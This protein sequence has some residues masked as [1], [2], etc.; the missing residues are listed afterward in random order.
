MACYLLIQFRTFY[1]RFLVSQVSQYKINTFST[2]KSMK[3]NKIVTFHLDK[4]QGGVGVS[5]INT[6]ER[7]CPRMLAVVRF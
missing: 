5:S 7:F 1:T 2:Q 6:I 3:K 4:N